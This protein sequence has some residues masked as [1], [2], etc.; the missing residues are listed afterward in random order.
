MPREYI[1]I[2]EPEVDGRLYYNSRLDM[3]EALLP[4]P[5]QSCH[6]ADL[7]ETPQGDLLCCFFAGQKGEGWSDVNVYLSRL[8]AEESR[9][10]E[11]VRVSDDDTRSEQNPSLFLHPNGEIWLLYTAHVSKTPGMELPPHANLQYTSQIRCRRSKDGGRTFGKTEVLFSRPGSF[12]RQKIQVLQNGRFLFGNW[13]CFDD[14]TRNGS[15]ITVIQISDDQGET[16]R[17]VEIPKSRGLVHCNLVERPDGRL[18]AFF[19]SRGAD[20]LYRSESEDLGEHWTEPESIALPNNNSSISA[21]PLQSGAIALAYNA[22]GFGEDRKEARWPRQR[23]PITLALS[24][25]DGLTWDLRRIVEGAEG[26]C[27]R[28]NAVN[29]K[30]YEYPVLLQGKDGTIHLA[31]TWG[32]RRAVKYVRVEEGWIRGEKELDEGLRY[33]F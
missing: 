29:N 7:L 9:W 6:A 32:N 17:M 15:D 12:C 3:V 33:Q 5:C 1:K 2:A 21:I 8:P 4:N 26:F 14:D 23:A 24:E 30:R 28:R 16:W 20:Y 18:A 10:S 22:C 13:L 31:Y 19:R 11:P 25:D 27:G